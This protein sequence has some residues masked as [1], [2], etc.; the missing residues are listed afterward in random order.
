MLKFFQNEELLLND[1]DLFLLIP[2]GSS[3]LSFDDDADEPKYEEWVR[4][5]VKD[6]PILK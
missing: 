2:E 5:A 6:L 1:C 3:E 4:F